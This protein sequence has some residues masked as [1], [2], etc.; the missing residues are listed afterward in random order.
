[1]LISMPSW[2]INISWQKKRKE[3]ISDI[4]Y[5]C[6]C[7]HTKVIWNNI[8]PLFR[9]GSEKLANRILSS[10]QKLRQYNWEVWLSA[11]PGKIWKPEEWVF[12]ESQAVAMCWLI[13][14]LRSTWLGDEEIFKRTVNWTFWVGDLWVYFP[15]LVL[16]NKVYWKCIFP[17]SGRQ[18]DPFYGCQ[19]P[20]FLICLWSGNGVKMQARHRPTNRALHP[21]RWSHY[22]YLRIKAVKIKDHCWTPDVVLPYRDRSG[23]WWKIRREEKNGYDF[24]FC[25]ISANILCFRKP[26][27]IDTANCIAVTKEYIS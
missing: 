15:F 25:N 20:S 26:Y 19:P 24:S 8:T 6:I 12:M 10:V 2:E 4:V 11:L 3:N 13:R 16:T 17:K 9:G 23:S 27:T 1:M 18:N 5:R 22:S 14:D 7:W 21:W